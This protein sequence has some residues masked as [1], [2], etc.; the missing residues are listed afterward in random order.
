MLHEEKIV[1]KF[2]ESACVKKL[3]ISGWCTLTMDLSMLIIGDEHRL[4][5]I[6]EGTNLNEYKLTN[7][8]K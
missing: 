2:L 6:L 8:P 1:K 5:R 7:L 3:C 4:D